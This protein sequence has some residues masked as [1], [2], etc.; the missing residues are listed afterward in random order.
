MATSAGEYQP[1]Y[2]PIQ[3]TQLSSGTKTGTVHNVSVMC[4]SLTILYVV[5][6]FI[7]NSSTHRVV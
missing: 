2:D 1:S 6:M 3:Q 5:R 4:V 7:F